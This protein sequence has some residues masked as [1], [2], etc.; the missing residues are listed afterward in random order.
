MR[1]R[2]VAAALACLVL[3]ACGAGSPAVTPSLAGPAV[4]GRDSAPPPGEH[5]LK[6]WLSF[7]ELP[8]GPLAP[9]TP[10]PDSSGLDN[11]ARVVMPEASSRIPS[12][13]VIPDASGAAVRFAEPCDKGPDC[14]RGILEVED[15]PGL[16][17][18]SA[19]FSYGADLRLRLSDLREGSNVV[20]KGFSTG[21]GGQW[22]LQVDDARGFPSCILVDSDTGEVV[23]VLGDRTVADGSWHRTI[24]DRSGDELTL[25]VDGQISGLERTRST[26]N[27]AS[28]APVRVAGKHVKLDG[29]FYFGDLDNVFL[30]IAG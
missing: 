6:L 29:D 30:R 17:P 20:Q 3:G 14:V 27:I 19:D 13:L 16:S 26:P 11:D 23:R 8:E 1:P 28:T 10:V 5:R 9:G 12:P 21:E 18:G 4:G 22:K 15:D 7:D 2:S 24:C 25:T